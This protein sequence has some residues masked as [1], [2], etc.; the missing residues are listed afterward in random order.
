MDDKR[1]VDHFALIGVGSTGP[2][3]RDELIPTAS[4]PTTDTSIQLSPKTYDLTPQHQQPIVDLAIIDRTHGEDPPA[5]YETI[6]TT[7][8]NFSANLNHSGLRNHEMYLCIR[9]GRDKPPI[10]DIGVLFE[11]RE[12]VMENVSV[13]ETTPHG[14]PASIFSSYNRERT[15]ITYR[16]AASMILCNTLAVTDICVIMES[17]G[18]TPPHSFNKINKNLN[19]SMFGSNIYLCYKKSVI[20]PIRIQYRP[21]ILYTFPPTDDN[22]YYTFPDKTPLFCFP[23]GAFIERWPSKVTLQS[24]AP[25]FST[26]LLSHTKQY[27]ACISFYE[28][29]NAY[30]RLLLTNNDLINRLDIDNDHLYAST[31][32]VIFSRHPFFDTLRRFLFTIYQLIVSSGM[33]TSNNNQLI[34]HIPLIEQYLKH[35]FYHVPFPS[36]SK[37][38]I[39]VEYDEPLLIVLPEDHGLPQNGAS[40]VDLLKN[41]GTDNTLTLFLFALLES[42]VL[43]HSLRSSVLTGVVEAVNSMLFPFQWQCPY[44]PLC[45]LA[46]SDVLSAPCPFIIGIDSRYFDVCE[47]PPD[48]ICVDLDTN[49][50]IGGTEE[51]KHWS[52]KMFPKKPFRLLKQSL[53]EIESQV[54]NTYQQR[55]YDLR[56][57][58]KRNRN[59]FE[60]RIQM[61]Q[62]ERNMETRIRDVFLRFMC[63]CFYGYKQFLRPILRRPNQLST[64]ASVL[65]EFDSFLH[66]RDSS[67]AKFYSYILRTQ[68]FSRFIEERSFLSSSTLNQV[69][70]INDNLHHNYSL[71]FFDECCTK[72]KAIIENNEQQ[73]FYLLDIHDITTN[74]LSEKTTLILPEFIDSNHSGING[75][76]DSIN[77][78]S[79]SINDEN[80]I[81]GQQKNDIINL[82][83]PQEQT[84]ISSMKIIPNSPMVKRSKFER[85]KCQ[86]VARENKTKPTQWAYC[87]LS[88]VYSLWF[89]HL[90][91]MI[92]C[93]TS[94]RDILNYAYKILVQMNRQHL[95][96][97]DEICFRVIIQLC[98]VYDYPILAVKSYSFMKKT[99]VEWNAVTY[100]AYNKAVYE[101]TWARRDRWA[102]LR[103]VVRA[104]WAFKTAH[105][106]RQN[107]R[108]RRPSTSS[109]DD[110]DSDGAMSTDS[111][112]VFSNISC[113]PTTSTHPTRTL[114]SNDNLKDNRGN[115]PNQDDTLSSVLSSLAGTIK[116]ITESPFFPKMAFKKLPTMD[117][118]T[119]T[120]II[121][122][123]NT[124]N[125]N[126]ISIHETAE[127]SSLSNILDMPSKLDFSALQSIAHQ[128]ARSDA[129]ILMTTSDIEIGDIG[130][131]SYRLPVAPRSS[132]THN[133]QQS[134]R[135]SISCLD[136]QTQSTI[137][138]KWELTSRTQVLSND[139]LGL[140]NPT[141]KV[142]IPQLITNRTSSV[143]NKPFAN[144]ISSSTGVK[145][146]TNSILKE[147]EQQQEE[148]ISLLHIP[149]SLTQ[150]RAKFNQSGFSALYNPKN[151]NTIKS[152][153]LDRFA[154]LKTSVKSTTIPLTQSKSLYTVKNPTIIKERTLARDNSNSKLR[155]SLSSLISQQSSNSSSLN[156]NN[157]NGMD[158]NNI[159]D[160]IKALR[161]NPSSVAIPI[162][163][164]NNENSSIPN[165]IIEISS[166]NRCSS[167]NQFL[168]DEEI[169]NGWSPDDS[170][171]H[172]ICVHCGEKTIPKLSINIRD[173][174]VMNTNTTSTKD[175]STVTTP[176]NNSTQQT[177]IEKMKQS[178]RLQSSSSTITVHYL[179]P[180]VLRKEL[181]NIIETSDQNSNDLY[182]ID[183]KEKHPI[184][185][186][187]LIWF[188]RRIHVSSYLFQM[189]LRS[190]LYS[191][192]NETKRDIK[193][194]KCI[195]GQEFIDEKNSIRIRCMWD[196]AISHSDIAEPM[197]KTWEHD[198]YDG[199]H[200]PV[201]NALITD[202]HSTVTG[203]D[204]F[205]NNIDRV[206]RSI[207]ACIEQND[208]DNPIRLFIKESSKSIRRR[209]RRRSMYREILF[210][211]IVALGREKLS[212]DAFDR[213]YNNVFQK[214]ND[215]QR[216]LICDFDKCPSLAAVMC[217]RLFSSLEL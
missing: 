86:K 115:N 32:I 40:F 96:N 84:Q 88:N 85:D 9:R 147:E 23:M 209:I 136:D 43:V 157:I 172:T 189:L 208:L 192:E 197:Y 60:L 81:H 213:E 42:K 22:P 162:I 141:P 129:G 55:L 100:G 203:N 17:R 127:K 49:I 73:T 156:T 6:W 16:R 62:L 114:G 63:T 200:T 107:Q 8:N 89:M 144:S 51:Q 44:I 185:F 57:R 199:C 167:C 25:I 99:G 59:D 146:T 133:Q 116:D 149:T 164:N 179:S 195:L 132:Q 140:L 210:L 98:G 135:R 67:Y 178:F 216:Q 1:L 202:E 201:A 54:L 215:K 182:K 12:K 109:F 79:T 142:S 66:S 64:D 80:K 47:P 5:G 165:R 53:D 126:N 138:I 75:H 90:P 198:G 41:L 150:L 120:K 29:F 95:T 152:Y 130:M 103:S 93:Y 20:Y 158:I 183:F 36:P 34:D 122:T 18:E 31:C 101:G 166:C 194:N 117:G 15:L 137:P 124:N 108:N 128:T 58:L 125:N 173:N 113:I 143:M 121:R 170:E 78:Q 207:V 52:V 38:R 50:I 19:R 217:R 77:K 2:I 153:A 94:P 83:L 196:S 39:F 212:Y 68:M 188:F 87:L 168:Y 76:N 74:F 211:A 92:E 61:I 123:T 14:Y 26:F 169:M 148:V 159:H 21:R 70:L 71:A 10:T 134:T 91:T 160:D 177:M 161:I 112:A 118:Y 119:D 184:L 30:D 3:E 176:T 163:N 48:V 105:R 72:V 27:G 145:S 69:T 154:D 174:T 11:G 190:L 205:D 151:L 186:W 46:L 131:L 155:G 214:L 35:F 97:P 187:N 204:L 181:E 171:L 106:Y 28:L 33:T 82:K 180:L 111:N 45:P 13:I 206:I 56:T 104:V 175:D 193:K 102:T 37:P 139:P 191:S 24:V 7:P 4:S 65:F 110:D